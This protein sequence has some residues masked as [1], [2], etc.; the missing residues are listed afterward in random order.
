M[1]VRTDKPVKQWVLV[2]YLKGDQMMIR[3][4]FVAAALV[5]S[6]AVAFA[7]DGALKLNDD[8]HVVPNPPLPYGALTGSAV[9]TS[10]KVLSVAT[11]T[12]NLYDAG[13]NQIGNAVAQGVQ[14]APG[15]RWIYN[16]PA[17]MSFDHAKIS[18]VS[19]F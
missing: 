17:A 1:P 8:L 10:D 2:K 11:I 19:A 15:Q 18:N 6:S 9:N 12:F 13:N 5:A 3:R 16:A 4:V 14:I 7:A